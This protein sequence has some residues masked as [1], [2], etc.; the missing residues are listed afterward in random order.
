MLPAERA[1]NT[2]YPPLA[3][4]IGLEL[5]GLGVARSLARG[6]VE[7]VGLEVD[8]SRPTARTRHAR[9]YPI[10]AFGGP[11]LVD[12]LLAFATKL[13]NRPVLFATKEATVATLSS[14]RDR[15][16]TS[17]RYVLPPPETVE[18][19]TDKAGFQQVAECEDAPVP[20]AALLTD[21]ADLGRVATFEFPCVLKPDRHIAA[22]E[23]RFR[24]AYKVEDFANLQSLY[25]EIRTVHSRMIVQEWIEGTD[26]DI[27]F[28]LQYRNEVGRLLASFTG[29]KIRTWPTQTGGTAS[30]A[31]APEVAGSLE[32]LTNTFF[33]ATGCVGILGMEFKRDRRSGRFLM[34]EPTIARTDHQ[35]E[36]ATLNGI[37]L[38]LVAYRDLTVGPPAIAR[39]PITPRIWRDPV[40]D[41]MAAGVPGAATM[42]KGKIVDAYWRC[43]D[44]APWLAL[45][46]RRLRH[47]LRRPGRP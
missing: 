22:Y 28:C 13:P 44:P 23:A 41:A 5:N 7:V 17:Y 31:P 38:P 16:A 20:R 37:N 18:V 43:D 25:A 45:Q 27:Y 47:R 34:V 19:L 10:R 1:A 36:V 11:E 2:P 9:C 26:A 24:K 39:A 46:R 12:D 14:A 33:E 15:L 21:P 35:A 40:A 6:G 29:R 42:P 32:P 8:P 4:V 3:V 30:C